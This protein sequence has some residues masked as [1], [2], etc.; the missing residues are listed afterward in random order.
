MT[1]ATEDDI[2]NLYGPELLDLIGDRQ[3]DG[4]IDHGA[5]ARAL[6]DADALIDSYLSV[7]YRLPLADPP[8]FLRLLAVDIAVYRTTLS[9]LQATEEMRVRYED[10]VSHLKRIAKGEAGLG[11]PQE[12]ADDQEGLVASSVRMVF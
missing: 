1:Y 2:A 9:R 12:E 5:L 7:R 4:Q 11:L 3:G 6:G 8:A 10:A